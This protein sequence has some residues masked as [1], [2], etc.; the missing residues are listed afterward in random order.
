MLRKIDGVDKISE[1]RFYVERSFQGG[2]RS[3]VLD[4][5]G[6]KE[7]NAAA[8]QPVLA[9]EST[10]AERSEVF[11]SS[12]VFIIL[13]GIRANVVDDWEP[14]LSRKGLGDHVGRWYEANQRED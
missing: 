1:V 8:V 10:D 2:Q 4:V 11:G 7:V 12:Y 9:Y 6:A 14:K 5:D 13:I 3:F